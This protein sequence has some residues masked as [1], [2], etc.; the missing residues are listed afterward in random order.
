MKFLSFY[1]YLIL[2]IECV[3]KVKTIYSYKKNIE[4]CKS[5]ISYCLKVNSKVEKPIIDLRN[6]KE[7]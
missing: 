7:F 2:G 5:N 1:L 6:Y 4:N 3:K